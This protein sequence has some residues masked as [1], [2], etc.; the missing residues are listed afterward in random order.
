LTLREPGSAVE[1]NRTT[2]FQNETLQIG[3]FETR[4]V[5]DACG[6]I[7]RQSRNV[8][9]LPFSGVFSKHEAPGRHIIGT[10]SHA[11]FIAADTPY[12]LSFPGGIGDRALTFRFGEDLVPE[13]LQRRNNSEPVASHGLLDGHAMLLRNLLW[14]RLKHGGSDEFEA[15]ALALD[16]LGR[17]L[18]SMHTGRLPV[19]RSTRAQRMRTL[20]RVKEAVALAPADKW[21]VAKAGENREPVAVSLVPRV[22]P[23]G[24]HVDLQFCLASASRTRSM[25]FLNPTTTSPPSRS[26]PGSR[27]IATSRHA[28]GVSSAVPL[29]CCGV[30]LR[31][32]R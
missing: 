29:R 5:S 2:L 32:S 9:V 28:S 8:V 16:L 20:E 3:L 27:I 12:R 1:I 13:Q 26:M 11:V 21:S 14:I 24:W 18:R 30:W 6:E 22:S 23:D 7:E 4:P 10:P 25:P 31:P 15:E 19:R 17:S